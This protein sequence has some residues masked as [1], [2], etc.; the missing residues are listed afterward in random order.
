MSS[1]PN[2]ATEW[3]EKRLK[4]QPDDCAEF[5]QVLAKLVFRTLF[6]YV[7]SCQLFL[8]LILFTLLH[9][10]VPL[11]LVEGKSGFSMVLAPGDVP[12]HSEHHHR[13]DVVHTGQ[14]ARPVVV[15]VVVW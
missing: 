6:I 10:F 4:L 8:H 5:P 15:V 2:L 13:H 7:N 1:S 14:A 12:E 11:C 3:R 9:L